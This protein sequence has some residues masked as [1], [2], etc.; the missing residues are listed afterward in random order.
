MANA[1]SPEDAHAARARGARGVGLVRTEHMFFKTAART[2]DVQLLIAAEALGS[3]AKAGALARLQT[4]QAEVRRRRP[5][6]LSCC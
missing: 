4:Y 5:P 3:P 6:A 1:D 2:R